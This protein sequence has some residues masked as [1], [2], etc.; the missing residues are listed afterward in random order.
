MK[1]CYRCDGWGHLARDCPTKSDV[2]NRVKRKAV[3]QGKA[4]PKKKVKADGKEKGV[5]ECFLCKQEHKIKEC[6]LMEM[7]SKNIS[8]LVQLDLKTRELKING[9]EKVPEFLKE[10]QIKVAKKQAAYVVSEKIKARVKDVF[11][12][13]EIDAVAEL[14][15]TKSKDR[16]KKR[17]VVEKK[18]K[19]EVQ[20]S[21]NKTS[22]LEEGQEDEE[23]A[24]DGQSTE[25]PEVIYI[26]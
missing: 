8:I 3:Y 13:L 14:E 12:Q 20:L 11:K 9:N 21:Q 5:I 26:D 1:Q 4:S 23:E 15:A 6:P 18:C 22:T 25:E 2:P 16:E 10:D 24:E 7:L 17:S 19:E